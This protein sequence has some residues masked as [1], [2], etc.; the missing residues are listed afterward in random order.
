MTLICAN[1]DESTVAYIELAIQL[2]N[3]PDIGYRSLAVKNL[4]CGLRPQDLE[5]LYLASLENMVWQ[6]VFCGLI[7]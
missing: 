6:M 1:D 7:Y 3:S 4:T 2:V 5:D